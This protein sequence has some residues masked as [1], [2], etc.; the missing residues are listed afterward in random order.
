MRCKRVHDD[1]RVARIERGD[2]LVGQDDLGLLHQRARDGDALLLAAREV[3]GAL[4]GEAGDVELLERG[5]RDRDVL[6]GPEL[7]DAR[8]ASA[9]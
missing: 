5:E 3:V 7:E 6:V 8:A 9:T 2:R 4:G 1:A